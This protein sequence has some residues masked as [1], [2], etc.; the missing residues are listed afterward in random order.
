MIHAP[1]ESCPVT[2]RVLRRTGWLTQTIK[3][4]RAACGAFCVL[5]AA[6][7]AALAVDAV[8]GLYPSG[9]IAVDVLILCLFLAAAGYIARQYWRNRFNPRRVARQIES[10]LGLLDSQLPPLP[11]ESA[12]E[13]S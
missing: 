11:A 5:L 2:Y 10:R 9:L 3:V 12:M 6:G 8:L 1:A 7:L 13:Y 4:A